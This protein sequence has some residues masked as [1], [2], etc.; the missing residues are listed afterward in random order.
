[1]DQDYDADLD[2]GDGEEIRIFNDAI[3]YR[4]GEHWQFRLWLK[5]ENKYARKS[6]NTRNRA[7][8]IERGRDFYLELYANLK[9]GKTYFSIDAKKR[10]GD[11][12]LASPAGC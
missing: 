2:A 7:T 5:R 4:R 6:L 3:I 1:M 10:R 8:A 11:V 12:S 9:Q